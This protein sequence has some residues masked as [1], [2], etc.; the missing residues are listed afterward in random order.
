MGDGGHCALGR[1]LLQVSHLVYSHE[2]EGQTLVDTFY[3]VGLLPLVVASS[4]GLDK[5]DSSLHCEWRISLSDGS[6]ARRWLVTGY[7]TMRES[8]VPCDSE[9][10][11]PPL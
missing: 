9:Q 6:S 11:T 2:T 7:E 5:P 1:T 4:D 3:Q 8:S 10:G